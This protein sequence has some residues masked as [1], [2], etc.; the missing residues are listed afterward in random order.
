MFLV[1]CTVCVLSVCLGCVVLFKMMKWAY[2]P[3]TYKVS[4]S[5]HRSASFV[6][7]ANKSSIEETIVLNLV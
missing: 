2:P 6:G 5:F 3:Y 1:A 7:A 4:S